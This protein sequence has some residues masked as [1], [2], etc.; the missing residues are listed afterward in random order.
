MTK[1][2]KIKLFTPEDFAKKAT[3]LDTG[4]LS[5]V[6]T[7]SEDDI[8]KLPRYERAP[9]YFT[10]EAVLADVCSS[11]EER[12]GMDQHGFIAEYFARIVD[13]GYALD[14]G[15]PRDD[16]D[17]K[18]IP[19][20]RV[21]S[22]VDRTC[23]L[24]ATI[25]LPNVERWLLDVTYAHWCNA[26]RKGDK[27]TEKQRNAIAT[28]LEDYMYATAFTFYFE[29]YF[30]MYEMQA[31]LDGA[32]DLMFHALRLPYVP[33]RW[34]TAQQ[35]LAKTRKARRAAAEKAEREHAEQTKK[36]TV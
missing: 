15:G 31:K 1:D 3:W 8:R 30:S 17:V 21:L 29:D 2:T 32:F 18:N 14:W 23:T 34:Y 36:A 35:K 5:Y 10:L 33:T 4:C 26:I 24:Q 9:E 20:F 11:P 16:D 25:P 22:V 7:F 12:A 6:L 27:L 28:L 19:S 13:D